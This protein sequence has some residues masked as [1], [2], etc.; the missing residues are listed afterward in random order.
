[1]EYRSIEKLGIEVSLHGFGCMRFPLLEDG[2][3]YYVEAERMID[4]SFP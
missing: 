4:K 3:T 1:M 2:K